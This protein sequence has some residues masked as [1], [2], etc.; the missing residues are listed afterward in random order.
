MLL[1][2][3]Q[4]PATWKMVYGMDVC[5][6]RQLIIAGDDEGFLHLVDKRTKKRTSAKIQVHKKGSKTVGVHC[7]PCSGD[8]F[9]TASE[10]R[11]A[12]KTSDVQFHQ[13]AKVQKVD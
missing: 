3:W 2:G 1:P 6:S 13:R 7:N 8:V 9:M 12:A 10:C 5:R 11:K 4:G